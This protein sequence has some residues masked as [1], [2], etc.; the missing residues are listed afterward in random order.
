MHGEDTNPQFLGHAEYGLSTMP[1]IDQTDSSGRQ[2]R[3]NVMKN[4]QDAGYVPVILAEKA[5]SGEGEGIA[6]T[7]AKFSFDL[8]YHFL[9]APAL[10]LTS[11]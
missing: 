5:E 4:I 2:E 11:S 9:A 3:L 8:L 10:S 1:V 7:S 6:K